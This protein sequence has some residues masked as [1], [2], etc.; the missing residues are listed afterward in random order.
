MAPVGSYELLV[1]LIRTSGDS[2]TRAVGRAPLQRC[3]LPCCGAFCPGA[4][5][6]GE[7]PAGAGATR[8]LRRG[9][10]RVR[11]P[12]SRAIRDRRAA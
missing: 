2:R 7:R 11:S 6:D 12:G 10:L 4:A 8:Q 9:G 5:V 3:G 1:W